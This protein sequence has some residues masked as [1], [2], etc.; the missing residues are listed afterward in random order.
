MEKYAQILNMPHHRS[1]T[2][3]R[4]SQF[5][6]AA[7]FAPFA[8]LTGFEAAIEETARQTEGE[9]TLD[10]EEIACINACLTRLK[11]EIGGHP[12]ILVT[13]FVPDG[14]KA[15]GSYRNIHERAVKIDENH[16]ILVVESGE[17]I[18]FKRITRI[19]WEEKA[20]EFVENP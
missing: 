6:R 1:P 3:A 11:A 10:E 18:P 5:R 13:F 12:R 4:M 8:A 20:G 19:K 7:Q 14:K 9:I 15:G 16:Q 2:R 17:N